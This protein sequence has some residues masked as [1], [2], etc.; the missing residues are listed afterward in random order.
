MN[1]GCALTLLGKIKAAQGDPSCLERAVM[2]C[3]ELLAEPTLH[4]LTAECALVYINL[5]EALRSLGA[6]SVAD[7]RARYFESAVDSL[8][9]AA[10]QVAPSVYAPLVEPKPI[11]FN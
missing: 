3:Q 5:A 7:E 8:A 6:I 11:S 1:R 2:A 10:R 9:M 4:N